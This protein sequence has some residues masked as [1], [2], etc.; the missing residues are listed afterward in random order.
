M[1]NTPATTDT[2]PLPLLLAVA[3]AL[4]MDRDASL[5]ESVD[6]RRGMTRAVAL[7]RLLSEDGPAPAPV[8]CPRSNDTVS[9]W[10]EGATLLYMPDPTAS[11]PGPYIDGETVECSGCG[12]N[13]PVTPIA[14][15][16]RSVG[17]Q[18]VA[19]LAAH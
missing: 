19:R 2:A 18:Y 17:R 8:P 4:E 1:T 6:Y 13:V 14:D 12:A 15:H 10:H 11:D 16:V 5:G 3:H 9:R 7:L